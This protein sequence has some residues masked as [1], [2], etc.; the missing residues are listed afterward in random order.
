MQRAAMDRMD[1]DLVDQDRLGLLA[2]DREVHEGVGARVPAQQVEFMGIDGHRGGL[3]AVPVH[4]GR[5]LAGLA[6]VVH[7]LAGHLTVLGGE[8]GTGGGHGM[9]TS[10]LD[11]DDVG[12]RLAG[13]AGDGEAPGAGA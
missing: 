3:D 5:Q 10:G 13:G 2:V 9:W 1:L 6:Q 7:L 8:C 4:H 11:V 12:P